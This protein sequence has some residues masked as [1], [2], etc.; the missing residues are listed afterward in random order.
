MSLA[1]PSLLRAA[2]S[3]TVISVVQ[4]AS[5]GL[6]FILSVIIA[7]TFGTGRTTDAYFMATSTAELAAK[8]L[9]GGTLTAVLL[10]LF[11]ELLTRGERAR[12][13]ALFSAVASLAL[14]VFTALGGLFMIFARP[15][16]AFVAPGFPSETAALTTQLLRLAIPAYA[17]SF[18]ADLLIVPLHAHRRF[19]L[20]ALSRL[21]VP[22]TTVLFVLGFAPRF[23]VA[24]LVVGGLVG[25]ALH[26][27]II[28][29]GLARAGY[30]PRLASPL[31]NPHVRRV[32]AL[33]AP[34]ALSALAAQGAGIVYRILVSHEPAG[35]LA[36]L[37]FGEKIFTMANLL[38]LG[39]ITQVAFPVFAEAAATSP[40]VARDRLRTAARLVT[41]LGIPLTVGIIALREPLVRVLYERGA[42][43]AEATALTAKLVPLYV[44]GLLGNGWSSLLGHLALAFQ[45][46]RASVMVN[47]V[48]QL[49]AAALFA[50]FVPRFGVEALA[51]VSGIGPFILTALY[52][53][54]LRSR[55]Q[56]LTAALIDRQFIAMGASG[57]A[58]AV[59]VQ[60]VITLLGSLPSN[61]LR[62]ALTLVLGG[63]SG[64]ATYLA[65]A[66]LLRVP[67]VGTVRTLLQHMT[68]R[69]TSA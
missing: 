37:K 25:T 38:F 57:A 8:L 69:R 31:R 20:P 42:F 52:L 60:A 54:A 65:S 36:S 27:G 24:S 6:S 21:A 43:T 16:T 40:A 35:S 12:A 48:L 49:I 11:V 59:A 67:E 34:F 26:A 55:V 17:L 23:G 58:C 10:P 3:G 32:L 13:W 41:F 47:I 28:L 50:I 29:R 45:A 51:L 39:A 30:L 7:S 15:L 22:A 62:D 53:L 4:A 1:T 14:L 9:L 18:L 33:T 61:F 63:I 56:R 66:W 19:A 2:K 5:Y 68:P 44:L 46:T 64:L